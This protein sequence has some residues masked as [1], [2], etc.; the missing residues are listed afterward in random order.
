MALAN[1]PQHS[2]RFQPIKLFL[3]HLS[4][5]SPA[6]PETVTGNAEFTAQFTEKY[7][8]TYY[9]Q[10]LI[11]A[12]AKI[13]SIRTVEERFK[14][15]SE[16]Y[17][18]REDIYLKD[19]DIADA[20]ETLENEIEKYNLEV[21]KVNKGFANAVENTSAVNG[22][23]VTYIAFFALLWAVLKKLLGGV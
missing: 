17:K 2:G 15:I 13:G 5:W 22:F 4:T 18:I 1:A 8:F 6:L 3:H 14:A 23:S 21:E 10:D 19:P 20:L 11:D 7:R 9:A 12:V 16:A